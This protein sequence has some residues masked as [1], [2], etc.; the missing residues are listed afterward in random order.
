MGEMKYHQEGWGLFV[1]FFQKKICVCVFA[2]SWG[3]ALEKSP[4]N[5]G[6]EI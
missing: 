3:L 1:Y 5:W 4:W 2:H 6:L